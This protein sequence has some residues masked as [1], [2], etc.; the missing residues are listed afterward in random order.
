VASGMLDTATLL[1]LGVI[2]VET[3]FNVSVKKKEK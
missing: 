3:G 1:I 2:F